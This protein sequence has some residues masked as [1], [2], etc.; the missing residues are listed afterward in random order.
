MDA[1]TVRILFGFL[2][3]T[4]PYF[5]G[6]RAQSGFDYYYHT[7]FCSHKPKTHMNRITLPDNSYIDLYSSVKDL[8]IRR[9]KDFQIWSIRESGIGS[10]ITAVGNHFGR[11]HELLSA[12]KTNDAIK[13]AENLHFNLFCILE[14]VDNLALSFATLIHS[15]DGHVITDTSEENLNRILDNLSNRGLTVDLVQTQVSEL[16]KKF[17][18]N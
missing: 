17:L 4:F 16:K 1:G 2:A 10:D 14:G 3:F 7:L 15:I 18:T 8:P 5:I 6:G 12:G 9:F 13:E 11:L